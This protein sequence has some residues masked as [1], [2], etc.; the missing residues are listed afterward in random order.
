LIREQ[1]VASG[2]AVRQSAAAGTARGVADELA[3]A[4]AGW[5]T[6]QRRPVLERL[7]ADLETVHKDYLT[8][9]E[10]LLEEMPD[11]WEFGSPGYSAHIRAAAALLRRL[12]REYEPV[13]IR[14]RA[15]AETLADGSL[16][17]AERYFVEAVLSYFPSGELRADGQGQAAGTSAGQFLERLSHSPGEPGSQQLGEMI[18]H[19]LRQHRDS[20]VHVCYAYAQ[21]QLAWSDTDGK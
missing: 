5:F 18:R 19:T 10:T 14:V 13:R 1:I 20:W 7:A 8:I 11:A 17:A 2:V 12:R 6:G 15:T 9:F 3:D 21:A 4:V 16:P